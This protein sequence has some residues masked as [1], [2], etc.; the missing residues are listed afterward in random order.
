[1]FFQ[2][3]QKTA[4]FYE[5]LLCNIL[6]DITYEE[7]FKIV[8]DFHSRVYRI[9]NNSYENKTKN[10]NKNHKNDAYLVPRTISLHIAEIHY[11]LR[12]LNKIK[13]R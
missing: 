11:S 10:F 1:M 5:T 13:T 8:P 12:Y 7:E 3:K 4:E 6:E 9:F 2:V